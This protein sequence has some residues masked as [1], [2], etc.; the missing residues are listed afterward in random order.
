MVVYHGIVRD[1]HIELDGEAVLADGTHVEVR[2]TDP[3]T[4]A[5]ASEESLIARLRSAGVLIAPPPLDVADTAAAFT[6]IVVQ[7]EPLSA[8]IGRERR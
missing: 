5:Q 3:C 4:T 6:P 7:G 8:Q 2:P 1:R